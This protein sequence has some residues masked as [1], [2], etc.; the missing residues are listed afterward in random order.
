[1][2]QWDL[3]TA[4]WNLIKFWKTNTIGFALLGLTKLYTDEIEANTTK[5]LIIKNAAGKDMKVVFTDA[6]GARDFEFIGSDTV[7]KAAVASNGE[8]T[9]SKITAPIPYDATNT[10]GAPGATAIVAAFGAAAPG[11]IGVYKDTG[12]SGKTYLCIADSAGWKVIE[13][14]AAV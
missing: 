7:K 2:A 4:I 11:K 14:T 8:A 3:P 13:G 9:F 6:A 5:D 12:T 1:M 10:S